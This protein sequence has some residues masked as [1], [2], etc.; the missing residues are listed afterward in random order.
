MTGFR[1]LIHLK[2]QLRSC[3]GM[4]EGVTV[5]QL[6][7]FKGHSPRALMVEEL[8]DRNLGPVTVMT[9]EIIVQYL[10]L[11]GLDHCFT[12][13]S[14]SVLWMDSVLY[15]NQIFNWENISTLCN[16]FLFWHYSP[17][18]TLSSSKIILLCSWSCYS[19]LPLQFLMPCSL[20]LPQMTQATLTQIFLC[21]EC[22]LV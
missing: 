9:R 21:V 15:G 7:E 4:V 14:S 3:P 6:S 19:H 16:C 22:L 12:W 8:C 17:L 10:R 11:T 13:N 2:W 20:D 1:L 5:I 18:W